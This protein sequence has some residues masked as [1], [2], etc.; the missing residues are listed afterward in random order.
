MQAYD[1]TKM[2]GTRQFGGVVKTV[3]GEEVRS[4]L[5]SG[6]IILKPGEALVRD[7]HEKSDE[8]FYVIRGELTVK[9][10]SGKE[11]HKVQAG[12]VFHIPQGQVHFSSNEG[13]EEVYVFW[14]MAA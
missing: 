11:R 9:D 5:M 3:L 4:N 7:L 1:P 13:A 14:T 8:V 6:V 10:E 2:E 12:K